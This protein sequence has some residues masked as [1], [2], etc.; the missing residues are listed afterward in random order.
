VQPQL[1][2]QAGGE[3]LVDGD[4]AALDRGI[5]VADRRACLCQCL[6]TATATSSPAS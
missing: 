5:A 4:R 3:V 6:A 1:V 2:D